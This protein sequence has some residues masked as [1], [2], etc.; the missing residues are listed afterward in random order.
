MRKIFSRSKVSWQRFQPILSPEG[1]W[2]R[3]GE[4]NYVL[5]R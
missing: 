1:G 5:G 4:D 3:V 2:R